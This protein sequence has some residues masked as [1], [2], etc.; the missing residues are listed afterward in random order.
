LIIE[1]DPAIVMGLKDAF[2]AES[3]VVSTAQDGEV[4]LAMALAENVDCIILDVMLPS[5]N[6]RDVCRAVR[7]QGIG[8]PILMLTSKSE[9]SDIV[10]GLEI[11][12][13]DYLTKP[14][15]LA[16]LIARVRALLRRKQALAASTTARLEFGDVVVDFDKLEATR[17]GSPIKMSVREFEVL[18]YLALREGTIVTRE[19]LLD[20]VWGY[21]VFPTT[22]TI[23]NY[24]LMLRKKLER[25][26]SAP[27]HLLTVHTLGYR[28]LRTAG[29]A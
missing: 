19:M 6:G 8:T 1:D 20:D 13:D 26:P 29:S 7:A 17:G 14:F 4:G 2:E 28:F 12:A 3:F 23:D 11:G 5:M 24:I 9:E 15:R 16:E 10:L 22:R 25:D 18:K 27:E 21:D